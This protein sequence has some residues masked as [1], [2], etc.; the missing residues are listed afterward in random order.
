MLLQVD[1]TFWVQLAN[2]AIFF[3]L[4][5]VI[6]LRRVGSE[7]KKRR[8]Y[9]NSVS[10][11]YSAYQT[12]GQTLR[13]KAEAIRAQARRDAEQT[14]AAARG[15]TSDESADL[16][17]DFNAKVQSAVEAAHATVGTELAQARTGSDAA[18]RGLADLLVERAIGSK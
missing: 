14:I 9:I 15:K 10:A 4:L 17:A 1:G 3:G 2:F 16:A 7:I 13:A 18:V 5:Y 8:E 12:E 11:D 6:F